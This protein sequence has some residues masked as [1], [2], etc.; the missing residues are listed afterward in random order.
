MARGS[1]YYKAVPESPENLELMNLIDEQ[2]TKLP[3]YG[4]RKMVVWLAKDKDLHVNRKRVQR[5]MRKMV[6]VQGG[7]GFVKMWQVLTRRS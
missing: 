5:L 2:Y 6:T 3:F 4:S 7:A 1:Y